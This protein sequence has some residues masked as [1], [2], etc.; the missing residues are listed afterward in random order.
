MCGAAELWP[1]FDQGDSFAAIEAENARLSAALRA[2]E[3]RNERMREA[4]E[5]IASCMCARGSFTPSCTAK[6]CVVCI[7]NAA[8]ATPEK[9]GKSDG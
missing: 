7:A 9:E 2:A 6:K 4:L 3:D 8:L 5:L 1:Q